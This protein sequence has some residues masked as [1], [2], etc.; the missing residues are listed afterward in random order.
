[1]IPIKNQDASYHNDLLFVFGHSFYISG[2]YL[3]SYRQNLLEQKTQT[4]QT[5]SRAATSITCKYINAGR[6]R[7]VILNNDNEVFNRIKGIS[8]EKI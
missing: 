1:M 8:L 2:H 6:V 4:S 3:G 7:N 5:T